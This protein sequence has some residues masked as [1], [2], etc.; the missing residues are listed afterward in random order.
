MS[1]RVTWKGSLNVSLVS[2][3]VKAYAASAP[4]NGQ[5][6]LNQ[7]H[8][9]CHGRIKYEKT[10][11]LHGPVTGDQIV[12]GYQYAQEQYV[13]V[14]LADLESCDDVVLSGLDD[15]PACLGGFCFEDSWSEQGA[16]CTSEGDACVAAGSAYDPGFRLCSNDDW[17]RVCIGG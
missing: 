12:M 13:V 7:L 9:A 14:D 1:P 15:D 3:A 17:Y 11:P 16:F 8:D 10:C 4:D 6:R 5:L 2:V